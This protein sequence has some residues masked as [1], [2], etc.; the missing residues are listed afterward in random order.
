M[1]EVL[2]R[3]K[4]EVK[5]LEDTL[6]PYTPDSIFPNNWFSSHENGSIVLYPM[7]AENRRLERRE[8]IYDFLRKIK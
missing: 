8:D 7:F 6:H 1:V 2:R 4:I 3:Y 5:V